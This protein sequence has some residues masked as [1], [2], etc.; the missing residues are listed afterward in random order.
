MDARIGSAYSPL[1][2][3]GLSTSLPS[4]AVSP[5]ASNNQQTI[6]LVEKVTNLIQ[7]RSSTPFVIPA[8][9]TLGLG[10]NN[11]RF[12]DIVVHND[13]VE[14]KFREDIPNFAFKRGRYGSYKSKDIYILGTHSLT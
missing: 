14:E 5:K 6:Q 4:P 11:K 7:D 8:G 10:S 9:R 2:L 1:K 12:D 3:P 13:I